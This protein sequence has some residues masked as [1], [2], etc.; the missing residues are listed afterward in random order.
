MDLRFT[1]PVRA[2]AQL[3]SA[4][5]HFVEHLFKSARVLVRLE[6]GFIG[7]PD[8]R[9]TFLLAINQCLR[10]CPNTAVCLPS[11]AVELLEQS[12]SLASEIYGTGHVIESVSS[13]S[14][15]NFTAIVNVG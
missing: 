6:D 15:S 3:L 12:N 2:A 5:E 9:E 4:P 11:S 13:D 10:F 14:F 1:R 7:L 8:A